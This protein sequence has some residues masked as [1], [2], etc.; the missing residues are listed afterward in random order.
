M[1]E[2]IMNTRPRFYFGE[3]AKIPHGSRN[4]KALS[5]YVVQFAKDHNLE[6]LQDDMYNV[7]VFKN[8][9]KGYEEAPMVMIQ[10]HLDMVCEKNKDVAYNFDTDPLDLYVDD[11]NVIHA[12]GTTLGADDCQGVAY[13][14]AILEDNTLQHPALECIF[15]VQEEIG[16]LG[17]IAMDPTWIRGKRLISLDGGGEYVTGLSTAGGCQCDITKTITWQENTDA[18]YAIHV[19]GLAG[20]H[21]GGEIHKEKGNANQ[22]VNRI[23]KSL[24]LAGINLRLVSVEGG[25]KMNAIPREA[26]ALFAAKEDAEAIERIVAEETKKIQK[27]LEFSDAGLKIA[28]EQV[29][30][31]KRAMTKE[32]TEQVIDYMFLMPNGFQHRS[33]AIEGLTLTSLNLGV[34]RTTETEVTLTVSIRSALESGIENVSNI[35]AALAK[36]LG[37]AFATSSYYPAWNYNENSHLRTYF[38]Q[39]VEEILHRGIETVGSHGGMETGVFAK[40]DEDMDII[41]MGPNAKNCHTPDECMDLD[42]FDRAYHILCKTIENAKA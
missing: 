38:A 12:R 42:S 22:I 4:E 3:C 36:V 5:D 2:F 33:M 27:E 34:V 9:S 6:Y 24:L 32:T 10:A 17:A 41:T 29:A 13:M 23:L 31:A 18:T 37:F 16:L 26:D 40:L 21:S 11:A 20:G 14:L 1:S 35:L 28:L 30:C 7:V 15:T 25:L 8:A 19:T 39:A